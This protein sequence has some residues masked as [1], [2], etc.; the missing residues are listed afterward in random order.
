MKARSIVGWSCLVIVVGCGGDPDPED[1][2]AVSIDSYAGGK[3]VSSCAGTLVA[4][5][6]VVTSGRCVE[7][8]D[9]ARVSTSKQKAE[10]QR[11]V[12]Y[13]FNWT[14]DQSLH[15]IEHDIVVLVLKTPLEGKYATWSTES[16]SGH[17]VTIAGQKAHLSSQPPALRPYAWS[18]PQGVGK[19]G[20]G[21]RRYDGSLVGIYLGT[22]KTSRTGYVAHVNEVAIVAWVQAQIDGVG[23]TSSALHVLN[24]GGGGGG[25]GG[26]DS[27][28]GGGDEGAGDGTGDGDLPE[29]LEN[30]P[31]SSEQP[32][33]PT[34]PSTEEPTDPST[35][36]PKEEEPPPDKYDPEERKELPPDFKDDTDRRDYNK[37]SN[38][39]KPLEQQRWYAPDG[40]Y[41]KPDPNRPGH[42][43]QYDASGK[44]INADIETH[45]L[46]SWMS[47]SAYNVMTKWCQRSGVICERH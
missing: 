14:D 47:D 4:P 38:A 20:A 45:N 17:D 39:H 26:D 3:R 15:T 41:Y 21:V 16:A 44:Q 11:V 8:G 27:A 7:H 23:T 36:E 19:M 12:S 28:G 18:I 40:S 2:A 35:E 32:E 43:Q 37:R 9:A 25:G 10:V 22:G 29:D 42:W 6:V 34:D 13:D 46:P 33:E 31:D 30:P 24:Q 1:P 5:R